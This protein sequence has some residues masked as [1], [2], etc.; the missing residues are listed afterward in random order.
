MPGRERGQVLWRD[1]P[2][3]ALLAR[4]LVTCA[5]IGL[6]YIARVNHEGMAGVIVGYVGSYWLPV[7]SRATD[8]R[9]PQPPPPQET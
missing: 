9:A 5:L 8:R 6:A 3:L 1:T 2:H 4:F 7:S